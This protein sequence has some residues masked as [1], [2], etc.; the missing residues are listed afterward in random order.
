MVLVDG[1]ATATV[2]LYFFLFIFAKSLKNYSK[3]RKLIKSNFVELHM[4]RFIR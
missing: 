1:C 4:S 3:S 2:V